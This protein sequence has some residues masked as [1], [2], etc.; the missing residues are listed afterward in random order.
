MSSKIKKHI[1]LDKDDVDWYQTTFPKSSLSHL[2][3]MLLKHYR[4]VV[5][6]EPSTYAEIAIKHLQEDL[7]SGHEN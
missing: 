7:E 4:G 6:A 1:D 5:E 3:T 2:L